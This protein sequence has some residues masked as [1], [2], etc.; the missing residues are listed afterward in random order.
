MHFFGSRN[1]SGSEIN[2]WRTLFT[3]IDALRDHECCHFACVCACVNAKVLK[4]NLWL[5]ECI[6]QITP[7]QLRAHFPL[8]Y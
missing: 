5:L 6:G 4:L 1:F 8:V 7:N 3:L 2:R